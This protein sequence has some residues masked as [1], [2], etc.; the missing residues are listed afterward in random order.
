MAANNRSLFITQSL[1]T[2]RKIRSGQVKRK[3]QHLYSALQRKAS[4]I[5]QNTPADKEKNYKA[6]F[7]ALEVKYSSEHL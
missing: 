4:E 2:L 6:V 7:S 1:K 5:L 3:Q